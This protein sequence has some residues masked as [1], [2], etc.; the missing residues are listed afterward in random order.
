MSRVDV[1]KFICKLR[2]IQHGLL[3]DIEGLENI[4]IKPKSAR[5]VSHGEGA[6]ESGSESEDEDVDILMQQRTTFVRKAIRRTTDA[7]KC[8]YQKSEAV[9]RE[10]RLIVKEFLASIT[11]GKK[12]ANCSGSVQELSTIRLELTPLVESPQPIGKTNM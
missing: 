1:N 2:L 8:R 5:K 3:L 10:R 12:C 6:E 4:H 11:K 9:F 7:N